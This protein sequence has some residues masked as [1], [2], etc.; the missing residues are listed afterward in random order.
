MFQVS[1]KD[2]ICLMTGAGQGIGRAT[3]RILAQ[4]ELKGM[5]ILDIAGCEDVERELRAL[6]TEVQSFAADASDEEAVRG[7]VDATITRWGRIDI[8]VNVAGI[9]CMT[10]LETTSAA[11]WDRVLAVNLRAAFLTMKYCP[12]VMK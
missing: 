12:P 1:L 9:A 10:D 2:Q 7:S 4:A 6:G 8:L 5:T 11:Q 3:A